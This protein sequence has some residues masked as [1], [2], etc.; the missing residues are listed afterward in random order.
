MDILGVAEVHLS[1]EDDNEQK[2]V[3]S[4]PEEEHNSSND[5]ENKFQKAIGAWRSIDLHNTIRKL[6][7]AASDI[8]AHQRDSLIQRKDLAQ[9]TKDFRKLDDTGKLNEYKGIL[10]AYQTF[11]DLLTNHGKDSSTAFLQLY[12]SISEA[13]DPY[14][15]LEASVE[16]LVIAEDTLPKVTAEKE[17]LQKNVNRLT[18]QLEETE[19]KL[20][21]ERTTRKKLEAEQES[22]ARE[23]ESSWNR[24]LDEKQDNW[25]STRK[26]LEEK[27]ENQDRLLKELKASYEV[28]QRLGQGEE[29]DKSQSTA[30]AA[31]LDIVTSELE[32]A[33]H[34]LADMEARNEQLRRELAQAVSQSQVE[35]SSLSVEDDPSYL[36]LQSENSSLLRKLEAARFDKDTIRG[37]WEGKLRQAD[38]QKTAALSENHELRTK[39]AKWADYDDLRRELDMIKS[40]EFSTGDDDDALAADPNEHLANGS[41]GKDKKDTLEQ[42]LLARN[43]KLTNEM[44]VLR[45]SHQDLQKQLED[46]QEELSRTNAELEKSQ[47]LTST[48]ENDLLR[49]QKEASF[50]SSALSVAASRYPQSSRRGAG[51]AAGGR[52]SPT[53]SIISGFDGHSHT[54]TS[55]ESLRAGEPAS[56]LGGGSG[57]L[58]MI[59]AQRDRFKQKNAQLEE[60]LQKTYNTVTSLRQEVATL[61]KDNLNLYEKTRYASAYSRTSQPTTTGSTSYL[62]TGPSSTNTT[63]SDTA[64]RYRTA[65]ES[66]LVSTPFTQFRS[67]ESMRAYRRLSLPERLIF[68]LTR[69]I[70]ANRTSR[71]LFAGYCVALHVLVFSMLYWMGTMDVERHATGLGEVAKDAVGAAIA[72]G[73]AGAGAAAG[74]G[75][76]N[77]GDWQEETFHGGR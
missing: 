62:P 1:N 49:V 31:E 58:P 25:D 24:V 39:V 38:R 73:G 66:S 8:V 48:L 56:S 6:D 53:S 32:R 22:K 63:A 42:L 34:R 46:L 26:A 19:K 72:A 64:D 28:S 67:R 10:K 12:S 55:L 21:E 69:I 9:K 60:E 17:H 33:S 77:G 61:Q 50:P 14:P 71:N 15:L 41:A 43:K 51:G 30:T 3:V 40:I 2:D 5:T 18:I 54:P 57:I 74:A 70:L 7:S 37:D 16:S 65:Y 13:P 52:T 76:G 36:R 20:E 29:G 45:V 47:N 68:S 44:T 23:I 75:G 4:N 35:K 27:V 11:I 59:Q